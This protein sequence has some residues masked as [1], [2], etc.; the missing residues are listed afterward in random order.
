MSE[1]IVRIFVSS[2]GD[3]MDERRRVEAVAERLNGEFE[4]R[5]KIELVRWETSYYSAHETFQKQ[6]PEAADCD[7]VVA[8]F[9]ARLGTELPQEFRKLPNCEPY[10]SGTAYEVLSAIQAR[11]SGKRLPDVYVFRCSKAPTIEIDD[12]NGPAIKTEWER[13]KRF[14]DTWFKTPDG[15]FLA[16]FQSFDSTDQFAAQIEDCVR[17][18]LVRQGFVEQGKIWDRILKGSPFPGLEPYDRQREVV[19]FGRYLDTAHAIERLRDAGNDGLP[20][21]L[22]IGASDAGKSS[23]MRAGV[24]PQLVRPGTIPDIDLWRKA[25]VLPGVD[26][27]MSLASAL[28]TDDALG[29]ELLNGDFATPEMLAKLFA[30]ADA[31]ASIAP[32]HTALGRAAV[33]RATELNSGEIRPARLALG[34]DQAERLFL[35]TNAGVADIFAGLL[36]AL[37]TNKLAYV[38]VALRSDAYSRFQLVDAFRALRV[39]G[40]I[41]DVVQPGRAELE[42][43]VI[44]P[45]AAC[46]PPLDFEVKDGH[47]LADT[48][49]AD[50]GGADELPLLQM[51]MSR[52]FK[53][54]AARAD[55]VLRFADY[56]GL[57]EA[58]SETAQDALMTLDGEAQSQLSALILALVSDIAFEPGTEMLVPAVNGFDRLE[59]E[60]NKPARTK[61]VDAF[62]ANH[63]LVAEEH[64]QMLRV[65]VAHEALLRI[66]PEAV[67]IIN[68]N[69]TAIRVRHLLQR[70]VRDWA[71]APAGD[72]RDYAA[73]PPALLGGAR[74]VMDLCGDDLSA[75]MRAFISQALELDSARRESEIQQRNVHDR[76]Q[77][78]EAL[79]ASELRLFRRT[80]AGLVLV[81]VLALVGLW[82]WR[83]AQSQRRLAETRLDAAVA[84]AN[85]LVSDFAY[86]FR[87]T[88]GVPIGL[89]QDILE[90]VDKFEEDLGE[91]TPQ[92]LASKAAAQGELATTLL[93]LGATTRALDRA[94]E[95]SDI[96]DTLAHSVPGNDGFQLGLSWSTKKVG[97]VLLARG[98]LSDAYDAYRKSF[99]IAT[100]LHGKDVTNADWQHDLSETDNKLGDVL[101]TQGKIDDAGAM[102]QNGLDVAKVPI[103]G[104]GDQLRW[105]SDLAWSYSKIGD[106]DVLEKK[107]EAAL[108]DYRNSLE[109]RKS[110]RCKR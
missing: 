106:I 15:G 44:R 32:I 109:R 11:Q 55:G 65:R 77:A 37:V 13:L 45:I 90:R 80:V 78:A 76:A 89:V 16:A 50:A 83:E 75:D 6:I 105:E 47:S 25:L 17:Q 66:W 39:K 100:K 62:I 99:D 108:A 33:A 18:W 34:I 85:S 59:F 22:L 67:K 42:D 10:P 31:E 40:V 63:L 103:R 71:A 102:Y 12:P 81:T 68:A 49:I 9:R 101:V 73:L 7:L 27:L 97:D 56:A 36:A 2:P 58:V 4:P 96:Y 87:H 82:Q 61:L 19:F 107:I 14:F 79:A 24:L 46:R 94:R 98:D 92:L 64:G 52:L 21:L 8:V 53:G 86:K 43:I 84:T 74:Q 69:A 54:E 95:A 20:F 104:D 26:P 29:G 1:Q 57:G 91:T 38:V 23:L 3:A 51:A 5:I 30:A 88:V 41:F 48:L 70:I 110:S 35:E 28:F 93:A 72:K 60:R